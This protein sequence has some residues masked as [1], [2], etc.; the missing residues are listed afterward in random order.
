MIEPRDLTGGARRRDSRAGLTLIEVM[1]AV[2]I[3]GTALVALVEGSSR[4]LAV[5]RQARNYEQARR[6]LGRVEAE[7]PLRLKDEITAGQESGSFRGGPSGWSWVRIIEDFGAVDEDRE[8]LFMVTTRVY[9]SQSGERRGME[10]TVQMLF[11]PENVDGKRSL[12]PK[13]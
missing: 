3:L 10:E 5:V 11:V 1:L 8:G 7:N 13:T 2:L 4:A 12:K 6:M 9:W